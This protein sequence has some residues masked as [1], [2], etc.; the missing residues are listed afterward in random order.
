MTTTILFTDDAH[1]LGPRGIV[2]AHERSQRVVGV[3]G[4]MCKTGLMDPRTKVFETLDREFRDHRIERAHHLG[5]I[6][7]GPIG[8]KQLV[9]RIEITENISDLL[10]SYI[11]VGKAAANELIQ[12]L[13]LRSK[14][15]HG[16][17][18]VLV[19][20][21]PRQGAHVEQLEPRDTSFEDGARG[22]LTRAA[23]RRLFR[24]LDVTTTRER[25]PGSD[26]NLGRYRCY[27]EVTLPDR[28]DPR[29]LRRGRAP[30]RDELDAA[31]AYAIAV[32]AATN[33]ARARHRSARAAATS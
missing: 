9:L 31:N 4:S 20:V 33:Q 26:R 30:Q 14:L 15:L 7:R 10:R 17:D 3:A 8:V 21:L 16:T 1:D 22:G 32:T 6:D 2:T 29:N 19:D 28:A 25:R 13:C 24:G 23:S 18:A 5:P 11:Q 27:H 12:L